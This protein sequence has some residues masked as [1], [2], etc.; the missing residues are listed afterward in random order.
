MHWYLQVLKKYNLFTGRAR[1]EAIQDL[2]A[3]VQMARSAAE[4]QPN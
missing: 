2:R 1:R 3:A 4:R